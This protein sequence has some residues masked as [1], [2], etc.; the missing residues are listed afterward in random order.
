MKV[1]VRRMD[2]K[3]IV[4]AIKEN[5][6]KAGGAR[7]KVFEMLEIGWAQLNRSFKQLKSCLVAK[8]ILVKLLECSTKSKTTSR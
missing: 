7:D 3:E 6:K 1:V 5:L 8:K 2:F 4:T